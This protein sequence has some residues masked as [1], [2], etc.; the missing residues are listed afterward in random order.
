MNK[1]TEAVAA[2]AEAGYWDSQY[3]LWSA[4]LIVAIL[5]LAGTWCFLCHRRAMAAQHLLVQDLRE[6]ADTFRYLV[7]TAHEGIA[8]VQNK[9][10]VYLNPRMC[11]MSGYNEAE[12]KALSSFIPLIHPSSR[13]EMMANYQRRVA[14]EAAPQRYE[15]LLL[16]KDGSS[17]PIE[18]SGV[19]IVWGGQPATLNMLTDISDRKAAEKKILY[20]AHHD[21]L[22]GLVNRTVLHERV[23]SAIDISSRSHTSFAVLFVD[24]NAFKQVNDAYGHEVGDALLQQVTLRIKQQLESADTLAR[25]GGDEFVVL[26]AAIKDNRDVNQ[27]MTRIKE[28]MAEVFQIKHHQLHCHVSQGAALYPED[29]TSVQALLSQADKN[30]YAD[31]CRFYSDLK[32]NGSDRQRNN[33]SHSPNS[34]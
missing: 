32:S 26:L 1:N 23:Q 7:E 10:L 29:G 34:Q 16:R 13:D 11:E 12:L 15:S 28:G 22:T 4:I 24:L 3:F 21:G 14:G 20:L 8:V 17:Y 18:L 19:A 9:R 2:L 31:K 33:A 30:M 6:S 25:V 5:F 27:V